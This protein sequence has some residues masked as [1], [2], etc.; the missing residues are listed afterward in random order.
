MLI[1]D[2]EQLE[3]FSEHES[4]AGG[5][6]PKSLL[7]RLT[8]RRIGLALNNQPL[9]NETLTIGKPISSAFTAGEISGL[10]TATYTED[11]NQTSKKVTLTGVSDIAQFNFAFTYSGGL[12]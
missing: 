10:L 6:A 1:S 7:L 2:L 9:L 12:M 3:V 11:S 5:L 4:I 8:D